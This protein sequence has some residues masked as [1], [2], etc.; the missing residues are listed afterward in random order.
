MNRHPVKRRTS[1]KRRSVATVDR[2]ELSQHT[3]SCHTCIGPQKSILSL[4]DARGWRVARG[5]F[6]DLL[7]EP[8]ELAHVRLSQHVHRHLD[9]LALARGAR[10][11]AERVVLPGERRDFELPPVLASRSKG[12]ASGWQV[13]LKRAV[14]IEATVRQLGSDLIS[15]TWPPAVAAD[16]RAAVLALG[17]PLLEQLTV[18]VSTEGGR[19]RVGS[20]ERAATLRVRCGEGWRFAL[21]TPR[22]ARGLPAGAARGAGGRWAPPGPSPRRRWAG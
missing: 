10:L 6:V 20:L 5:A 3:H 15:L 18:H 21:S 16:G 11:A 19:L 17:A 4:Q 2:I 14:K 8:R 12:A 1:R 9:A 22:A 13:V 7:R